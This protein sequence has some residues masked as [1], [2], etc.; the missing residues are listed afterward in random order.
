MLLPLGGSLLAA[1]LLTPSANAAGVARVH[2]DVHIRGAVVGGPSWFYYEAPLNTEVVHKGQSIASALGL[3]V[4][5]GG[6]V[7]PGFVV[8]GVLMVNVQPFPHYANPKVGQGWDESSNSAGGILAFA[9]LYPNP[10]RGFFVD[11]A[12]GPAGVQARSETTIPPSPRS[13]LLCPAVFP[14]CWEDNQPTK[15]EVKES[16]KLGIGFGVGSG[17]DFWLADQFSLGLAARMN[18]VYAN[19]SGR[20]Y[21]YLVP[22][23]GLEATYQ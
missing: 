23:L 20:Q 2:D 3:E 21:L 18:V 5:L 12:L 6:T 8:G 16:S 17:Y 14:S 10:S 22:T 7:L 15:L 11:V 1:C 4:A 19:G 13:E 9:R